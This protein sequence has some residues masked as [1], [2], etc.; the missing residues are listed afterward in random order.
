MTGGCR[1]R[2]EPNMNVS[3]RRFPAHR[4]AYARPSLERRTLL[5]RALSLCESVSH[6]SVQ[7]I[8]CVRR[9]PLRTAR[10][11]FDALAFLSLATSTA[12]GLAAGPFWRHLA[13]AAVC[14]GRARRTVASPSKPRIVTIG[15]RDDKASAR[16]QPTRHRCKVA[17]ETRL[18]GPFMVHSAAADD[19]SRLRGQPLPPVAGGGATLA[20]GPA[21]GQWTAQ[22][23]ATAE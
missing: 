20:F 4:E 1:R 9:F 19:A 15:A 22:N 13:V 17:R 14:R 21:G 10:G 11:D 6:S 8:G 3:P 5:E 12:T 2:H 16:S 23:Y 18:A 7:E